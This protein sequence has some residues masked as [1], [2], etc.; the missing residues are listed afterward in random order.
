MTSDYK[1]AVLATLTSD[2][3]TKPFSTSS[4]LVY[5]FDSMGI[6]HKEWVPAGE[7]ILL[8]R[9]SWKTQNGSCGF[10]QTLPRTGSY[11]T[12][13]QPMQRS[14]Q[15]SFWHPKALWWC[16]SLLTSSSALRLPKNKLD[17][18]RTP[19]WV[20]RRHPKVCNACIK[21][22]SRCVPGMLQWQHRW[23]TCV[24]AQ[25]TYFEGDNI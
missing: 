17:N 21:H 19:L 2:Q 7:L 18:A 16:R 11:I 4:E 1:D 24:H 22:P 13:C 3:L 10:V 15:R 12:M 14:L 6:V 5:L 8:Q 20:K 9:H 23:K 25:G